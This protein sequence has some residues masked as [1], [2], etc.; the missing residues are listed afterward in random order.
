MTLSTSEITYL[1]AI[2]DISKKNQITVT[3]IADFLNCSKPSVIRALKNLAKNELIIYQKELIKLTDKGFKYSKNITR[4]DEVFKKF[5]TDILLI[6]EETASIDASKLKD[7][8]S[9]YTVKKLE[10]YLIEQTKFEFIKEENYCICEF[11][12]CNTCK[13]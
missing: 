8:V 3:K 12:K 5:F 1:K 9:C 11:E 13:H 10:E 2:Y 6:D 7:H 4:R